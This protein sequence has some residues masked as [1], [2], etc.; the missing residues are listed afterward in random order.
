MST[1][2]IRITAY[3]DDCHGSLNLV[4]LSLSSVAETFYESNVFLK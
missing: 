4:T 1:R 2:Q 3:G